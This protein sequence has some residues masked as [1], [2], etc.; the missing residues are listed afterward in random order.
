[1]IDRRK[2]Y[3]SNFI[4]NSK[5]V[6]LGYSRC[7]FTWD[8]RHDQ[9][10]LIRER[11]DQAVA[12]PSWISEFQNVRVVHLPMDNSDHAPILLYLTDDQKGGERSFR[13]LRL[14]REMTIAFE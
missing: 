3:L 14:G 11:L 7:K 6:D 8:N 1:M 5:A 12:S 10:T 9:S 4:T 2:L 13:F